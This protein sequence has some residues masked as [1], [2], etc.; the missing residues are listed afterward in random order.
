M[1]QYE[2]EDERKDDERRWL[3]IAK[4]DAMM[5]RIQFFG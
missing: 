1:Q 4:A 2:T 3:V 5:S